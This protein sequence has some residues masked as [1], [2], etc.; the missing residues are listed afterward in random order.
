[1]TLL[2]GVVNDGTPFLDT[3]ILQISVKLVNLSINA[4]GIVLACGE[5]PLSFPFRVQILKWIAST[6][7]KALYISLNPSLSG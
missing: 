2:I 7:Q 3:G 4:I 6:I 5:M 1:M